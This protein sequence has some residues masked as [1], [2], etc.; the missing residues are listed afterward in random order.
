MRRLRSQLTLLFLI[1]AFAGI[2]GTTFVVLRLH[3]ADKRDYSM[4]LGSLLAPVLA[5]ALDRRTEVLLGELR[6]LEE[7]VP[8]RLGSA[9]RSTLRRAWASTLSRKL[10]GVS[11]V[12]TRAPGRPDLRI[13]PDGVAPESLG[14]VWPALDHG[15]SESRS[16]GG[17]ELRWS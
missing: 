12:E 10:A 1:A 8:V 6:L 2:G 16:A 9:E 7:A 15:L 11:A 14:E 3:A 17:V 4:E 13:A 5:D